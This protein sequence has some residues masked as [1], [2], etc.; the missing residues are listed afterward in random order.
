MNPRSQDYE[1]S[2][3]I[4]HQ[5]RDTMAIGDGGGGDGM[6]RRVTRL[7]LQQEMVGKELASISAK[8]DGLVANGASM[9]VQLARLPTYWGLWSALGIAA[10]LALAV[11]AILIAVLQYKTDIITMSNPPA[12]SPASIIVVPQSTGLPS[13]ALPSEPQAEKPTP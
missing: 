5:F 10:G 13:L 8:I 11:V 6:D 4:R 2:N 12:S 9:N 1:D 7:E 3:V